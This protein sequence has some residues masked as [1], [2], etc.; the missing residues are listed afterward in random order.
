MNAR[1]LRTLFIRTIRRKKLIK[2]CVRGISQAQLDDI[3]VPYKM[4]AW[5]IYSYETPLQ[6][7]K[8]A[9]IPNIS[10]T[11]EIVVKVKYAGVNPIDVKMMGGYGSQII[12]PLTGQNDI[13]FPKTF[14]REFSGVVVGKGLGAGDRLEIGD[15]VWGVVPLHYQGCHS[16]YVVLPQSCA[17][18]HPFFLSPLEGA[19][20]LY[21]GLTAYSGLFLSGNLSRPSCTRKR[22]FILGGSGGV[23]STAIQIC[24]AEGCFVATS[25]STDAIPMVRKLEPHRIVDYTNPDEEHDFDDEETYDIILDCC[26][27]GPDYAWKHNWKFKNYVTFTSPLVKNIDEQGIIKGGAKSVS[28]LL[29]QNISCG[30][31]KLGSIKWAFFIPSLRGIKYLKSLVD[32]EKLK[33]IIDSVHSFENTPEAYEKVLSGHLRG[34]VVIDMT[35]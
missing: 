35:V 14:G 27:L 8:K 2:Q 29:K 17:A 1:V 13:K 15:Q 24:R 19:A 22:V 5:E 12:D 3:T 18:I 10:Q 7:N 33:P 30:L 34:K 20:M 28:E 31:P 4:S 9:R 11:D 32:S 21:A 6:L 16:Q 26:G 25:C 23:G